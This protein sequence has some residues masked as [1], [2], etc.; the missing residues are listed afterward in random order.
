MNPN[1]ISPI[2][3]HKFVCNECEYKCCKLSDYNKHILTN[4]HKK[5][6]NPTNKIAEKKLYTCKCGK[7]YKHSSTFS[8][9]KKTCDV[10]NKVNDAEVMIINEADIKDLKELI[11]KFLHENHNL[12]KENQEFKNLLIDQQKQIID[13]IPKVGSKIINHNKTINHN[14]TNNNIIIN[15]F[16]FET[17]THIIEDPE[18]FKKMRILITNN[19]EVQ[20][21]IEMYKL[22]REDPKNNNLYLEKPTSRL[23]TTQ[24]ENGKMIKKTKTECYNNIM[25]RLKEI[26]IKY[27]ATNCDFK[28]KSQTIV[29]TNFIKRRFEIDKE[30]FADYDDDY[31]EDTETVKE[32]TDGFVEV[33]KG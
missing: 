18:F 2:V 11:T 27:L 32:I 19:E 15:G 1:E 21:F 7:I 3:V 9:H 23:I 31:D 26:F 10:Y 33:I 8:C 14:T 6:L 29:R 28:F 12:K 17:I 25:L 30:D 4:K 24:D 20:A 16:G 22:L 5:L 13:L